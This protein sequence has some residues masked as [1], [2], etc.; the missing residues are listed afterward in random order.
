MKRN[1]STRQ[2]KELNPKFRVLFLQPWLFAKTF[3]LHPGL[4]LGCTRQ[5][6]PSCPTCPWPSGPGASR[7]GHTCPVSG[8]RDDPVIRPPTFKKKRI[9]HC[10]LGT[11][12]SPCCSFAR[13]LVGNIVILGARLLTT[14]RTAQLSIVIFRQEDGRRFH[15]M[16]EVPTYPIFEKKCLVGS[17]PS[18]T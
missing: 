6:V 3:N 4:G 16:T 15:C 17:K 18:P 7:C 11:H 13:H 8:G 12:P 5:P 9:N 14:I 10:L 2:K 1:I